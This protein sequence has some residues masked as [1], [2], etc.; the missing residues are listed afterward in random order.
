MIF[1]APSRS[2]IGHM[3]F[4]SVEYFMTKDH[5][6]TN[7]MITNIYDDSTRNIIDRDSIHLVTGMLKLH[8]YIEEVILFPRLPAEYIEDVEFLE[9]QHG[10]IFKFLDSLNLNGINGKVTEEITK[11]LLDL[12]LEHNAFEESFI[13]PSFENV[14][15]KIFENV[16]F[17]DEWKCRYSE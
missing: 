1:I 3:E 8:I 4:E 17:P 7:D 16:A 14:D 5:Q 2:S 15:A 6:D 12:L 13:Y 11:R 9:K 10:Q